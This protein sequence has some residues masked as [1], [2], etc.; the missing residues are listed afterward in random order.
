MFSSER[1]FARQE[2]AD[3]AK[4]MKDA[5]RS[6]SL[7]IIFIRRNGRTKKWDLPKHSMKRR[8]STMS[9]V[10]FVS[11]GQCGNQINRVF[12]E[13]CDARRRRRQ[14]AQHPFFDDRGHPCGVFVDSEPK[15][16]ARIRRE[17]NVRNEFVVF[18]QRGRANNWAMGFNGP[19]GNRRNILAE[20]AID[21]FRRRVETLD[22]LEGCVV[23]HSL[24]GGTGSGTG[25]RIMVEL[26]DRFPRMYL[27]SVTVNGFSEA[28]RD[29]RRQRRPRT[30]SGA[31]STTS[32]T[33]AL[34]HY[35]AVLAMSHI[36]DTVDACFYF[37]NGRLLRQR[38]P[39][40]SKNQIKYST[41]VSVDDLNADIAD[42]V[43]GA[44]DPLVMR[45]GRKDTIRVCRGHLGRLISSTVPTCDFKILRIAHVERRTWDGVWTD[46]NALL[47][48]S[49]SRRYARA[50]R[51]PGVD[52]V[53]V[54]SQTICRGID[55][56]RIDND[57]KRFWWSDDID[58]R[59]PSI[60]A[61]LPTSRH[62]ANRCR[63]ATRVQNDTNMACVD[64]RAHLSRA[65][66]LM[67]AGAYV[68]WYDAHGADRVVINDAVGSVERVVKD[69][70]SVR[71]AGV[72]P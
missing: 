10:V 41:R 34:Q 22:R 26:R 17:L 20:K 63:C 53:V 13:R 15:V 14:G 58:V 55:R 71:R 2:S 5:H 28:S 54:A 72:Y 11:V 59:S 37:S 12:W 6:C 47:T 8:P 57:D 24:A 39:R 3:Q 61:Q 40:G 35:N 9:N 30:L 32:D 64:L 46:I 51:A 67:R 18:D 31:L 33:G 25:C 16:V 27:A 60:A 19:D 21:A 36:Q 23:T 43:I 65:R 69:Y 50:P 38:M 1:Y 70:E 52:D 56:P 7:K 68:H 29:G 62:R 49:S 66:E 44:L 45:T 42:G 4:N 48:T